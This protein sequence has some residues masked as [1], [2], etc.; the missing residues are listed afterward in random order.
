[1]SY[2]DLPDS[3]AAHFDAKAWD[4][5]VPSPSTVSDL[6]RQLDL[7]VIDH[8]NHGGPYSAVEAATAAVLAHPESTW[9]PDVLA[10]R[11]RQ[12]HYH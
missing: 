11:I 9:K 5:P 2:A 1:M 6:L 3:L 4:A 10:Y 12:L 7:A 8:L